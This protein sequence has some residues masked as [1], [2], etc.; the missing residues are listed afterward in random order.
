M[1]QWLLSFFVGLGVGLYY[2]PAPSN[3]VGEVHVACPRIPACPQALPC[4]EDSTTL[5]SLVEHQSLLFTCYKELAHERDGLDS[6][7][8]EVV[9]LRTEIRDWRERYYNSQ[10]N[11]PSHD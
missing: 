9:N 1:I 11:C 2:R 7:R 5:A 10:P 4:P 3:M 6:C 8:N